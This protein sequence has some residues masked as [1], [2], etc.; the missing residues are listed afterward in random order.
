MALQEIPFPSS[1]G[2]DTIQAWL[3]EPTVDPVAIVHIIHGLGE[4]SRRYLHMISAL[5]D[6]GF[7]V[8]AGDHAGHGRTAMESGV[9]ADAGDD[10]DRVVV[11][12]ELALQEQARRAHPELPY[13][14]FGHSWGSVIARVMALDP[15]AK[16]DALALCGIAAQ[17]HG[18]E[19]TLDRD[20]L[21][22][23]AA[24]HGAEPAPQYLVDQVF[25]G[26]IDRFGQDAGPTAWVAKD[27]GIVADHARDPFNN[28]GAPMSARFLQGFVDA[29]DQANDVA[30]YEKFPDVPVA[31]FAG[32]EDPVTN[33][34]EGAQHVADRFTAADRTVELHLYPDLRHEVHNEPES[35]VDV[36]QAL[37]A[38][39]TRAATPARGGR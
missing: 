23:L 11:A 37:I 36:E 30:F 9:W 38:F 31:I 18:I 15:R 32:Q 26:F 4:H 6:A 29:Y 10:A 19:Q 28:F 5:V 22:A 13:I 1:N 21:A 25:E 24:S 17:M 34:G 2:R 16:L 33:Y 7:V 3:Y 8:V 27:P 12:D 20:A 39:A 35:R 14:V